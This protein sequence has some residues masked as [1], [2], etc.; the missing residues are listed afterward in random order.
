MQMTSSF[1]ESPLYR[2][3]DG[4]SR[5]VLLTAEDVR[6]F[7][8][9]PER[10]PSEA[11]TFIRPRQVNLPRRNIESAELEVL[12]YQR[13]RIGVYHIGR[14]SLITPDTDKSIDRQGDVEYSFSGHTCEYPKAGEVWSRWAAE[15][16]IER[17]EWAKYPA[18]YHECW[19]HVTQTAWFTAHRKAA[20]YGTDDF[21]T[22]D[23]REM[24]NKFSFY[25]ALGEAVNGPGGY[26]GSNLD[27]LAD[28]L[29]SR[30]AKGQFHVTWESFP[31][32]RNH[33]G[34]EFT[35]ATVGVLEEFGVSVIFK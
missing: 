26:F 15:N 5:D 7:F 29:S 10:E 28:C 22:I 18:E 32:S 2:L 3:I 11:F 30:E 23:G 16:P 24:F 14:A 20:R 34:E 33:L 31:S 35:S 12:N 21:V 8:M 4:D 1:S 9:D 6:G 13:E 19:L 17:G 25:C 27:A